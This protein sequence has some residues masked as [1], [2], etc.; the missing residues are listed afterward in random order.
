MKL[1]LI[2]A[3]SGQS[4]NDF[5]N[6]YCE[7][8]HSMASSKPT[9]HFVVFLFEFLNIIQILTSDNISIPKP[10]DILWNCNRFGIKQKQIPSAVISQRFYFFKSEEWQ[11][12]AFTCSYFGFRRISRGVLTAMLYTFTPPSMAHYF[13]FFSILEIRPL[14]HLLCTS[15]NKSDNNVYTYV[16]V[17][18]WWVLARYVL[19]YMHKYVY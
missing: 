6:F 19:V 17:H 4:T 2:S 3:L 13:P 8:G 5:R 9:A 14:W 11:S 15:I 16:Y 18:T 7:T 10:I 12:C 1:V